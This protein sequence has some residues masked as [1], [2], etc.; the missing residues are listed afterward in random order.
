MT[1]TFSRR[2]FAL[3]LCTG[4]LCL[5]NFSA[6]AK[7]EEL[8]QSAPPPPPAA[9]LQGV[10]ILVGA[11]VGLLPSIRPSYF[12]TAPVEHPWVLWLPENNMDSSWYTLHDA[13]RLMAVS[14]YILNG[15]A[16]SAASAGLVF[17]LHY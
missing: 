12:E 11:L 16:R 2:S 17:G 7:S 10:R 3:A 6:H 9:G 15:G 4:L 8:S 5:G 1:T 14:P 13:D